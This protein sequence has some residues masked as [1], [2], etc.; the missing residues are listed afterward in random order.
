M[1]Q[2]GDRF[3][4]S[5]ELLVSGTHPP[6]VPANI[7]IICAVFTG[8]EAKEFPTIHFVRKCWVMLQNVN[9]RHGLTSWKTRRRQH[10]NTFLFLTRHFPMS[11]VPVIRRKQCFAR[12][13]QRILPGAHLP[14]S[15]LKSSAM[16]ALECAPPLQSVIAIG[17]D[18]CIAVPLAIK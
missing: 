11:T 1:V 14:A 2:K 4:L 15:P 18:F 3:I 12:W 9:G 16:D 13:C 5:C 8:V 6:A 10:T 7:Q 17:M